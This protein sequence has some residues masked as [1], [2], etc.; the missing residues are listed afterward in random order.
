MCDIRTRNCQIPNDVRKAG[1]RQWS[2]TDETDLPPGFEVVTDEWASWYHA[3]ERLANS[4]WRISKGYS[5][6]EHIQP[7]TLETVIRELV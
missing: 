6:W 5:S 7:R 1:N 2:R 4:D 3:M